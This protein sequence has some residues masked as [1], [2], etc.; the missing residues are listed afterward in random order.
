M[1]RSLPLEP[2]L[3]AGE[4]QRELTE[5][6]EKCA[7]LDALAPILGVPLVRIAGHPSVSEWMTPEQAAAALREAQ[8]AVLDD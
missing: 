3:A 6:R 2:F 4:V 5:L 1:G 8:Q 7:R